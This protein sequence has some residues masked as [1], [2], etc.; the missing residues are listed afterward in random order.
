MESVDLPIATDCAYVS[1]YRRIPFIS[2]LFIIFTLLDP[3]VLNVWLCERERERISQ[4]LEITFICLFF[5][6]FLHLFDSRNA[7]SAAF[8]FLS[9]R[10][11]ASPRS[12]LPTKYLLW[13]LFF[14]FFAFISSHQLF[15][16]NESAPFLKLARNSSTGKPYNLQGF[17]GI[18]NPTKT[19]TENLE[20]G[21]TGKP[22]NL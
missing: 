22:Y 19:V 1:T 13:F 5:C 6:F 9:Y 10:R 2:T 7:S 16:S 4:T 3:L 18:P 17:S 11:S 21:P 15:L 14:S 12:L 20:N 8:C